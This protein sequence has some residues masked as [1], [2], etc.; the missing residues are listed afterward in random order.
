MNN[1][2]LK[3]IIISKD[4]LVGYLLSD[5]HP[6]GKSKANFFQKHGYTKRN[7]DKLR[8]QLLILINE[9]EIS[10]TINSEF[11]QK[12]IIDGKI[13]S[14]LKETIRVRTIWIDDPKKNEIRLVTC[15]P[16]NS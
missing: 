1:K 6:T 13:H 9:N 12:H 10:K 3:N 8:E 16:I 5:T 7:V 4:K 14:Q 15:Y 11:G 2:N